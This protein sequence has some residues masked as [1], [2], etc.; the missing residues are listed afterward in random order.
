MDDDWKDDVE[1]MA[2]IEMIVSRAVAAADR[3][4]RCAII[5]IIFLMF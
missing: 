4:V 1:V 2:I 3:S 5:F